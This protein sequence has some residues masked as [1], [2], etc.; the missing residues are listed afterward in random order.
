MT[1]VAAFD[2]DGT[3][4]TSDCV[5]PFLREVAGTPQL[6]G[7][8]LLHPY[9]LAAAAWKRDRD[10]LKEASVVAAFAGRAEADIRELGEEFA[11]RVHA[12]R[13]RPEIVEHLDQH[14]ANGDAVVLV[15]ASLE[16]YLDPLARLLAV[17]DVLATK[18][19][20]DSAGLLTGEIDGPNCRGP[21]KV[22]RLHAWLDEHHGGRDNVHLTAYG[23]S[24]GDRELLADADTAHWVGKS[25]SA[26]AEVTK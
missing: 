8:L 21:E 16:T 19:A 10:A 14:L 12:E 11:R 6:V 25:G 1:Q 9:S 7:R 3:L 18:L 24:P 2:V 20:A 23:D 5:V 13:L 22:R 26:V 15:S 17:N 4:T